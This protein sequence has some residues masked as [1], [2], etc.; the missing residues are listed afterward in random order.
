MI[1]S[2]ES[3]RMSS[4]VSSRSSRACWDDVGKKSAK[5]PRMA[6]V[7]IGAGWMIGGGEEICREGWGFG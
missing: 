7:L 4:N 5:L 1:S 6:C 2:Y 3:L